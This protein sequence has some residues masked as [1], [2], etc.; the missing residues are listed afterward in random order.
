MTAHPGKKLLFMG[1]EFGPFTEWRSDAPLEWFLLLYDM[2]PQL[3]ECVRTLNRLYRETPALHDDSLDWEGFRW[4]QVDDRD[5][6]VFAFLRTDRDGNALL[7]LTNFTAAYHEV[8]RLG[9]P[10]AGTLTEILNTDRNVFGGSDQHNAAPLHT[11]E[12][13]Q[14]GFAHSVVMKVPPLATVYLRFDPDEG[15][16]AE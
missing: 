5:N 12:T 16:S 6:S 13:P 4:I 1:G 2:H 3:R 10:R 11:E 7:C 8:Y 15:A 9:L 14:G